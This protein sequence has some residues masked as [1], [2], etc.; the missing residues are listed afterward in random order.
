MLIDDISKFILRLAHMIHYMIEDDEIH[1]L[2]KN[3][4][5][6]E[7]I[8]ALIAANQE[9]Q[10]QHQEQIDETLMSK[11]LARNIKVVYAN[12][13]DLKNIMN[14]KVIDARKL[15]RE[16]IKKDYQL[17]LVD[18]ELRDD[19]LYVQNRFYVSQDEVLYIEI[20]KHMHESSST[21]H[22]ERFVTYDL[23]N[24]YYY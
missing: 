22:F 17:Q 24:R 21:S 20:I 23:V 5:N 16:L 14:A 4:M 10:H 13:D 7:K 19:M 3:D 9:A 8:V 11:Q 15:S 6:F 18:C 2:A 12:D 1:K